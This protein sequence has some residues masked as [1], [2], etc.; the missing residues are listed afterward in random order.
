M[1]L[2]ALLLF[3]GTLTVNQYGMAASEVFTGSLGLFYF[4]E[5]STSEND[6]GTEVEAETNYQFVDV[7]F[8]YTLNQVCI[9]AKYLDATVTSSQTTS[10][11]SVSAKRTYSGPGIKL[12]L[13]IDSLILHYTHFIEPEVK[14]ETEGSTFSARTY[15]VREASAIDVGFGM[16]VNKVR[17]GIFFQILDFKIESYQD[18]SGEDIEVDLES[19]FT[20]PYLAVWADL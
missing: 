7:G 9:G 17:L 2:R 12:G 4:T 10:S 15:K 8:C 19:H 11:Y 6:R 1:K 16:K 13:S 20:A 18:S 3:I 14:D 5:S